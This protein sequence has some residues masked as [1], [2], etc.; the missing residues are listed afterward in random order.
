GALFKIAV[1][2]LGV[3]KGTMEWGIR[4]GK[5]AFAFG[6]DV[7]PMLLAVGFIV[8]FEAST[9]L[10]VG[11]VISNIFAIP[12]LSWGTD[13]TQTPALDVVGDVWNTQIR[14]LGIGAMVV[15]G[16]YSIIKISGSMSSAIK[17]SWRGIRGLEDTASLPR[18][19]QGISGKLLFSLLL[20][21]MI[22]SGIVYYMMTKSMLTTGV[23]TVLLFILAFF[24]VAVASYIVGLVGSSNSPVSGMTICTVLI[25]AGLFLIM[26]YTGPAGMLATLG[27][28]GVVCCAACTSGDICQDLKIGQIVGATPKKFQIAEILGAVSAAFIIAPTMTLLHKAYGIGTAARAGVPPLKAPQGVMFQ[29]LVGGLFGAEA[30]IPWNL[31]LVGALICVIAIII[32]RYVLAPRNGKFRLYPMPLAVGMYL[33]M[34]VILPM[35]IGG[36]V[37]EVVAHRLKKKGL[38]EEEQQAGVHRGLL[39]SSGLVA[40]E[41]IMG[42][43]IAVLMVMNCEIPWLKNPYA[44]SFGDEWLGNIVSVIGFALMTLILMRKCF[45]KDRAVK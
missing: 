11:N 28:A 37:Y 23:I 41:A 10:M 5:G 12:A 38:S 16:V 14:Y 1:S 24:F 2:V 30:Q 39:F 6:S 36:V 31:V 44:N 22:L 34:S 21:S 35:F 33:P 43:F 32:D 18:N 4:I 26:G 15:A 40:G 42:I 27:V 17:T 9:V 45:D 20:G 29:K 25:T 13:F 19:E 7:S 8:G 3:F